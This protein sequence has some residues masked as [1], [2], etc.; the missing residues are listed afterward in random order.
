V[1]KDR[2]AVD[3]GVWWGPWSWWLA[4]RV[5]HV[6]SFEANPAL[7]AKIGS[8]LPSNVTLHPVALSDQAGEAKL[9][10]P[11][12]GTGTEGRASLGPTQTAAPGWQQTTVETKRLDDFEL[13]DVGFLKVDVEG[14]ELSVLKGA[15][16][17]LQRT[18]P[19]V[20]VEIESLAEG[21]EHFDSIIEFMGD[22]SYAGSFFLNR[23]WHPIAD[24]DRQLA[25]QMAERLSHHGYATN[26]L[27]YVR[28]YA[29]NF[30]FRPT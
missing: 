29:H 6:D 12:G 14:H 19:I 24:L 21:D 28:R 10:I 18:R 20:M 30:L 16:N 13:G 26:L 11:G 22:H 9:W 1:P 3:V 15:T 25:R 5:P 27:L 7:V 8:V 17:L 4:R 23:R 2:D